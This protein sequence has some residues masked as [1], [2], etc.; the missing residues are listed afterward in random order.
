M[1]IQ[2]NV[3]TWLFVIL[4]QHIVTYTVFKFKVAVQAVISLQLKLMGNDLK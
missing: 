4:L 3:R 1:K 2:T